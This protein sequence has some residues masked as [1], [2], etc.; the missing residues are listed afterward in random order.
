[1][2]IQPLRRCHST[3]LISKKRGPSY[4]PRRVKVLLRDVIF[5]PDGIPRLKLNISAFNSSDGGTSSTSDTH[6]EQEGD[7]GSL[8][9]LTPESES[10]RQCTK[11]TLET[12]SPDPAHV[13]NDCYHHMPSSPLSSS[14]SSSSIS[15]S[16]YH[17]CKSFET[18]RERIYRLDSF[19]QELH[20]RSSR[21]LHEVE[22]VLK[23][24]RKY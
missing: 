17:S 19:I 15:S 16:S 6:E 5:A 8:R 2:K 4:M 24:G 3:T 21:A 12:P 18:L 7:T 20:H 23:T 10:L 11:H 13:H 22:E 9:D 1:M 14:S